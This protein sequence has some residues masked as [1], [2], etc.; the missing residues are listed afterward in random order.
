MIGYCY[1]ENLVSSL[2]SREHEKQINTIQ[3]LLDSKLILFYP[4][5][6]AFA[7]A[8]ATDPRDEVQQIME[9]KATDFPF[10][11]IPKIIIHEIQVLG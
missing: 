5:N 7:R 1:K 10:F 6:T 4:A 8:L 9:D 11:G 3:D 2:V